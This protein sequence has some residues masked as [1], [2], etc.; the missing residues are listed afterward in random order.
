MTPEAV[1]DSV[2]ATQRDNI[3][4][5][6]VVPSAAYDLEAWS[7]HVIERVRHWPSDQSLGILYDWSKAA[8]SAMWIHSDFNIG[9][10]GLTTTGKEAL[11]TLLT[12]R[13]LPLYFAFV[14]SPSLS[15]KVTRALVRHKTNSPY[16][17]TK[18]FFAHD[19]AE[20]WLRLQLEG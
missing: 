1:T 11:E 2:Y 19:Q 6:E 15:G 5:Y 8:V 9:E 13:K 14:V 7:S 18:P 12:Q 16:L 20:T 10:P 3:L 17:I 4:L